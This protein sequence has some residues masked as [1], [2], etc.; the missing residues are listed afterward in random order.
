MKASVH[1]IGI[2]LANLFIVSFVIL[3]LLAIWWKSIYALGMSVSALRVLSL[4]I[5]VIF[6]LTTIL[7]LITSKLSSRNKN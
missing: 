3:S 5:I 7:S 6:V 4:T 1:I 2:F